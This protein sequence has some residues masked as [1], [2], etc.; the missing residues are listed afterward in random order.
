[1]RSQPTIDCFGCSSEDAHRRH[2]SFGKYSHHVSVA[3][4]QDPVSHISHCFLPSTAVSPTSAIGSL[5]TF[6]RSLSFPL[7]LACSVALLSVCLSSTSCMSSRTG[8]SALS[9]TFWGGCLTL[10]HAQLHIPLSRWGSNWLP[11]SS[12]VPKHNKVT[13]QY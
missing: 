2:N 7:E 4:I 9:W 10:L 12:H 8:S 3:T 6:C 11:A 13:W 1:M 5:Q